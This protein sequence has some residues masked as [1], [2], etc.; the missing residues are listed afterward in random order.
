MVA[1]TRAMN[2]WA[3]LRSW[4]RKLRSLNPH[5]QSPRTVYSSLDVFPQSLTISRAEKQLISHHSVGEN[6]NKAQLANQESD[7]GLSLEMLV[8][9]SL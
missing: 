3:S 9:V 8:A 1:E 2:S 5:H 4:N 7:R 6:F